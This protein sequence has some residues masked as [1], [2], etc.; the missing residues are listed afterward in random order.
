MFKAVLFDLDGTLADTALDL[1]GALNKV[2]QKRGLPLQPMEAIRPLAS[3]G[4]SGLIELGTGIGK[5]EPEHA[6][7]RQAFLDEYE[8]CFHEQTV[9]FTGVNAMLRSLDE[10]QIKWGIITNKPQRFTNRLVPE[11]GLCIPPAVVVSGDTT[12]AAKPSTIP[13]FYACEQIGVAAEECL[14][15]G[16]AERDMQAGKNSGMTTVLAEWGYIAASDKPEKWLVDYAIQ[17]AS[18]ILELLKIK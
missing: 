1:G 4:A 15:V 13:M 14:Y 17:N 12:A 8:L 11:L 3:H 10:Q 2:L 16:D 7:L 6:A 9:L 5:N 18:Q